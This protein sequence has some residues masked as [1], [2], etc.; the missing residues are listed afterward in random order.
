MAIG[1]AGGQALADTTPMVS[2]SASPR[3]IFS[4]RR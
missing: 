3:H 2:L 1:G 4:G